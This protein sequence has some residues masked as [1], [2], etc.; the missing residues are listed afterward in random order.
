M[1]PFT[2]DRQIDESMR[3]A[4]DSGHVLNRKDEWVSAVGYNV[5]VEKT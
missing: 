2:F 3:I 1:S 4:D 5:R